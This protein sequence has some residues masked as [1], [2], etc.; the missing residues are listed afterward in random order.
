V[1]TGL[2]DLHGK[3]LADFNVSSS[4][5]NITHL[6]SGVYIVSIQFQSGEKRMMKVI[7]N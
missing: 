3:K 2:F 4:E 7:K 1:I 6:Q 5:L